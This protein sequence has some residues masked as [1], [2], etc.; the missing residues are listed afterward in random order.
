M[1]HV[2]S[3]GVPG[4]GVGKI[5]A[6]L[7]DRVE[8]AELQHRRAHRRVDRGA[9]RQ[10][11]RRRLHHLR[12]RQFRG[13]LRR[14]GGRRRVLIRDH[15]VP[16]ALGDLQRHFPPDAA[17][18]ADD[19]H[20]L[21]AEFLLGR[22]P[23]QLGLFERPVFDPE[24]LEPRQRDVVAEDL[25]LLRLLRAPDLRHRGGGVMPPSASSSA[26]APLI[27]WM[28]LTK[29]SRRD[30][31][32][33]LVLAEPEQP[34]AGDDDD[35]RVAVAEGGRRRLGERLVVRGVVLAIL[36]DPRRR[37]RSRI[38]A[39]SSFA[40]SHG[41]NIGEMRV[42]RKWSG[43]LVPSP[44]SSSAHVEL[45]KASASAEP[46]KCPMTRRFD[47]TAPRRYGKTSAT[48]EST[49]VTTLVTAGPPNAGRPARRACSSMNSPI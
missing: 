18:A 46:S 6:V 40:G 22:H 19:D 35:R 4:A 37:C 8:P 15:D 12:G 7:I 45:A 29:N 47:D 23:L 20:D 11:E 36:R 1:P 44:H 42:R 9:R 38:A 27:T 21:A 30:A 28:A 2:S 49:S 13:L 48:A 5:A 34:E 24:R 16:A 14:L 32:L 17:G 41:M 33:A 3:G 43:Q 39:V 10:V 25:E 26:F 31:R